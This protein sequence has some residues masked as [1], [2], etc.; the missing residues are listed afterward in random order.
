[1]ACRRR[2]ATRSTNTPTMDACM[3]VCCAAAT[4]GS[5][6]TMAACTR[7]GGTTFASAHSTL[8]CFP[9]VSPDC[10]NKLETT[11]CSSSS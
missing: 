9:S 7:R 1:M 4:A 6:Q 8:A 10:P 5:S 11:G 3:P 2:C